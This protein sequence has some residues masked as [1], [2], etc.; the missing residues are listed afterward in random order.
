MKIVLD[1]NV[2]VAGLLSLFGAPAQVL[3]L[4]LAARVRLCL[5]ARILIEYRDVLARPKFGFNTE[6]VADVLGF[7][8]QASEI[9]APT[10]W[11]LE[12]P[13]ASDAMFL[14]VARAGQARYL[15]TGNLKHFPARMRRDVMVVTPA[16]FLNEPAVK[17]L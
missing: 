13:D 14:E 16:Q 7:V 17:T 11:G 2:L 15:V 10:P 6:D 5:D 1:T 8:E 3:Q 12:L 4:I 9:V